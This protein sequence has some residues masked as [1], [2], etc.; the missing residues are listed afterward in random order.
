MQVGACLVE[1]YLYEDRSADM[2]GVIRLVSSL[3]SALPLG[4][5]QIEGPREREAG[6]QADDEDSHGRTIPRRRPSTIVTSGSRIT[7][8]IV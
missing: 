3:V 2:A 7:L 5:G 1:L 8:P 4:R 6:E